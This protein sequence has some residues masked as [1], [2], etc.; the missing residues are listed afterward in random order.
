MAD[1]DI[2]QQNRQD[3]QQSSSSSYP[4]PLATSNK[5]QH[6]LSNNNEGYHHPHHIPPAG[7][8][9]SPLSNIGN[10]IYKAAKRLSLTSSPSKDKDVDG[11]NPPA[12]PS[13]LRSA[14]AS[15]DIKKKNSVTGESDNNNYKKQGKE[16]K[17]KEKKPLVKMD[18]FNLRSRNNGTNASQPNL[19][20]ATVSSSQTEKS[21][22]GPPPTPPSKETFWWKGLVRQNI[23]TEE[24][25]MYRDASQQSL[26]EASIDAMHHH[27][28]ST[29]PQNSSRGER[30][31]MEAG[32]TGS[33]SK[34]T[35]YIPAH[36]GH[37]EQEDQMYDSTHHTREHWEQPSLQ[38]TATV[39]LTPSLVPPS[40]LHS[41]KLPSLPVTFPVQQGDR[42]A[43]TM[44]EDLSQLSSNSLQ[45]G[46][47]SISDKSLLM[48]D[49]FDVY[50]DGYSLEPKGFDNGS[51]FR[52][53][54]SMGERSLSDQ[55]LSSRTTTEA[56]VQ[57]RQ[58]FE[59]KQMSALESIQ[60]QQQKRHTYEQEQ[61]AEII[62]PR[63]ESNTPDVSSNSDT[64]PAS[65]VPL[66]AAIQLQQQQG[67]QEQQQQ[68]QQQP[69]GLSSSAPG[70]GN[71]S[72]MFD[73]LL[74]LIPGPNRP[75][76][77]SQLEWQRGFEELRQKRRDAAALTSSVGR[78]NSS[79]SRHSQ[80]SSDGRSRRHSMPD[81]PRGQ[82]REDHE[83]Q[84]GDNFRNP[85]LS[86]NQA[87]AAANIGAEGA[88]H[89]G[90][91]EVVTGVAKK[92]SGFENREQQLQQAPIQ[93]QS[94][95]ESQT[96]NVASFMEGTAEPRQ[97]TKRPAG[98]RTEPDNRPVVSPIGWMRGQDKD[99]V[100]IAFDE[101]MSTLS[102]PADTR[103]QL[104]PLPKERK[105][106][107]LQSN[108]T[109]AT[110]YQTPQS[111]PPQVF[112]DALLEYTGKTKRPSRD[113]FAF[114]VASATGPAVGSETTRTPI[115]GQPLGMWKNLSTTNIN[116]PSPGFAAESSF[117]NH[118]MQQQL[119]PT[120]QQH[121]TSLLGKGERRGLEER[122]QIL[123]KLRVLIRNGSI[124]WTGE[125]IKAGGSRALLQFCQHIQKTEETK[126]GQ[127]ERLL[128]QVIQ[129]IKAIVSLE[130]GVDSLV[131]ESIFF[132]LMRTLAIHE[133]PVLGPKSLDPA[134]VSKS[135]TGLFG[136][137]YASTSGSDVPGQRGRSSSIPKPI[138]SNSR[139][140][141]STP[142][143][144]SPALSV[145]QIPTFSNAQT[146][147]GILVAILSR[148]PELRD[149]ILR[150]I[151]ANPSSPS[152]Q[153]K[154]G[155]IDELYKY[156]EWIAYLKEVIH[157]C[158]VEI[159]LFNGEINER[160]SIATSGEA[161]HGN[162]VNSKVVSVGAG[163]ASMGS[164][165]QGSTQSMFSLDN[166]RRRRHSA[167]TP[168]QKIHSPIPTGGIKYEAGEDREV[169]AYLTAHLEL[170]SKL[171]FDV[172]ISSPALLFAKT[173]KE[174]KL[175]EVF[176]HQDLSAQ[177]EDLLIQL[178][179]VSCT[180]RVATS[181]P[182]DNLPV[183][184][185]FGTASYLQ[186]QQRQRQ[187]HQ[188]H[189]Q[190]LEHPTSPT[191]PTLLHSH[192]QPPSQQ[193]PSAYQQQ[194]HPL[195]GAKYD[196]KVVPQD[197]VRDTDIPARSSSL[198]SFTGGR[199]SSHEN[200]LVALGNYSS[201]GPQ[202]PKYG[203]G[204]ARSNS[205]FKPAHQYQ[206]H[207]VQ[208]VAD[209]AR[210]RKGAES[211]VSDDTS[212][213]ETPIGANGLAR[214]ISVKKTSADVQRE[215]KNCS[216]ASH[217]Q[218]GSRLVFA[219]GYS[220]R[221]V[222]S[223]DLTRAASA[224]RRATVGD[225]TS[226]HPTAVSRLPTV[227]PKSK[228]RPVSMDAK[229]RDG[230]G[231]S[232]IEYTTVKLDQPHQFRQQQNHQEQRQYQKS[233]VDA[234]TS[235]KT[236]TV[237]AQ[238][239]TMDREH[240]KPAI[241]KKPIS[242]GSTDTFGQGRRSSLNSISNV[243]VVNN[244]ANNNKNDQ[245]NTSSAAVA[246]FHGHTHL[247][248]D[249]SGSSSFSSTTSTF[250]ATS[251]SSVS[252][253]STHTRKNSILSS[254][255]KA[256]L[257]D[258][259]SRY[260]SDFLAS[261]SK[262]PIARTGSAIPTSVAIA[263]KEQRTEKEVRQF[264]NVDFD[265][266]IQEDVRKLALSS[267]S[268]SNILNGKIRC[269]SPLDSRLDIQATDPKVLE[270]PIIVPDDMSLTRNQRIQSQVSQIVL[271]PMTTKDIHQSNADKPEKQGEQFAK[272]I[273]ASSQRP[274]RRVSIGSSIPLP[275]PTNLSTKVWPSSLGD[276]AF[277][278]SSGIS[279]FYQQNGARRS[280]LDVSKLPS[281]ITSA[282]TVLP[283]PSSTAA[284]PIGDKT[285]LS[286]RI[287]MFERP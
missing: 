265:T 274:P 60:R 171:I 246:T 131:K 217:V 198:E 7:K 249:G 1:P 207:H 71:E 3:R 242:K 141:Y 270:A 287:R 121:L 230:V 19:V 262:P 172:H 109:N 234:R 271:P 46:A 104:E 153:W 31:E 151:I 135:K 77:P 199:Q 226:I 209:V 195:H 260:S 252:P 105:W 134:L 254:A 34:L 33:G 66:N 222:L 220:E 168:S 173:I 18:L 119:Q 191:S 37:T 190:F 98:K 65:S 197:M 204:I 146:S 27:P 286:E 64:S 187:R 175:E 39:A 114:N 24:D 245:T 89:S 87:T 235:S 251:T 23:C 16:K 155:S 148:E 186:L 118:Y 50:D 216:S 129:C 20:T 73:Q 48:E 214:Q 189:A 188:N 54:G 102:L 227:P 17:N 128:H 223:S 280:S 116:S 32:V 158:G 238:L 44:S 139:F 269:N 184:P 233:A 154:G 10:Q 69:L 36:A 178:S 51:R 267:S 279:R 164:A 126:L 63:G 122:E 28:Q 257:A 68:Q 93:Q 285:K 275:S 170:V 145:D 90:W 241:P 61:L 261:A 25:Y 130:G 57:T 35:P 40:K 237:A 144:S 9:R 203:G 29:Y 259:V 179:L 79:S 14:S 264:R 8:P 162:L 253:A 99:V 26:I 177:V 268:S 74:T 86:S 229:G 113:I 62:V 2:V 124:R 250:S 244:I 282:S 15:P 165:S 95:A 147:V 5:S 21:L 96:L 221:S 70:P 218:K 6:T 94:I 152:A 248:T 228:H 236:M 67:Q 194:Q 210:T 53:S 255:T 137:A 91:H 142:F 159:T 22:P 208:V 211:G 201:G 133:A 58:S 115:N 231:L 283:S 76:L 52:Q 56:M 281:S 215:T 266:R 97:Q 120:F 123:K 38:A 157:V 72:E 92:Q 276:P 140:G 169:L 284:G 256:S 41:S 272:E 138:H 180:T 108:D 55:Q 43:S 30:D 166:M 181:S 143:Q 277:G 49:V 232:R 239:E 47:S 247:S 136:G 106:A 88:L 185:P 224:T 205:Q 11:Y 161:R 206:Q 107:L 78:K 85:M 176:E 243:I 225:V 149:R 183:V 167:A 240:E 45:E 160:V 258:K 111:M 163:L 83:R 182:S 103:K 150:D 263:E 42:L 213:R 12:S 13:F 192:N 4:L 212:G 75:R 156:S 278:S 273:S 59:N 84:R 125:F 200:D 132:S 117:S 112:V 82:S 174:S 100:D 196:A 101:I 202:K 81:M 80:E 219:E 193:R 110:L 127:R